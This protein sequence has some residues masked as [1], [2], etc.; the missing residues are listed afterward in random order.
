MT[1]D[2]TSSAAST[3]GNE[4]R[5]MTESMREASSSEWA[6]GSN[7]GADGNKVGHLRE[8]ILERLIS[9]TGKDQTTASQRDWFIATAL[10][11]RDRIIKS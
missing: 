10:V 1:K 5:H 2:A 11:A 8:L 6:H 4:K 9:T 7:N 3:I